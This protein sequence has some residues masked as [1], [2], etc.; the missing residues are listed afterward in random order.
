M[1]AR[2]VHALD[3]MI[4]IAGPVASVYASS[5][6]LALADEIDLDDTTAMLLRFAHGANGCLTA[7]FV[8]GDYWR[9]LAMGTKGWL[10]LRNDTELIARGLSGAPE[11]ITFDAID[12]EKA[13]LEAF[14]DAVAARQAFMV[15]PAEMVNGVAVL[16]SIEKS[17][18]RGRP[19]PIE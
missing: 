3:C 11:K 15:P 4:R 6:K 9:V 10:E 14:A 12:K 8:T 2:G 7:V 16:E 1:T 13:E 18:A 5:Q 19:I 17:S